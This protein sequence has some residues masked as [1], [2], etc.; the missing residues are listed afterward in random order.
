MP[1]CSAQGTDPVE[2]LMDITASYTFAA[3]PDRVWMMLTD[4]QVIAGCLPG[5]EK[6]EPLGDDRYR[7]DLTVAVAGVSGTYSGTVAM[8]DKQ[9]PTSFRL[10]VE[11]SGK[12]GFIK[13]GATIE[14]AAGGTGTIVNVKGDAQIG[15]L[16]ARIGQRLLGS[17]NKMMMD[18]F[19]ACLL[20]KAG[21]SSG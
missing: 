13:G 3:P 11:G 20:E 6:L 10:E 14:L 15:G 2:T 4:P 16:M 18:R 8:L 5:C 17:V 1:S 7:A 21:G 12:G 9:P 19:F